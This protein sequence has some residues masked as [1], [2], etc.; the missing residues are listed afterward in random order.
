LLLEWKSPRRLPAARAAWGRDS[1]PAYTFDHCHWVVAVVDPN[2][3]RCRSLYRRF[4]SILGANGVESAD[5]QLF[6]RTRHSFFQP[7]PISLAALLV[8]VTASDCAAALIRRHL[9]DKRCAAVLTR[10]L[11]AVP[12]TVRPPYCLHDLLSV[13]GLSSAEY[14]HKSIVI[15]NLWRAF[16]SQRS[17]MKILGYIVMSGQL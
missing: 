11:P 8:K 12:S 14:S 16:S 1:I 15:P 13:T 6:D 5:R 3:A 17:V 2:P 10:V 4:D 9:P 7:S